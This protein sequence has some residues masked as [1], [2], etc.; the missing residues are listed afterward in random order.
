[1]CGFQH[2]D[3]HI[4]NGGRSNNDMYYDEMEGMRHVFG[5][6]KNYAFFMEQQRAAAEKEERDFRKA[7]EKSLR[8]EKAE[9][10]RTT[11]RKDQDQ[12]YKVGC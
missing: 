10:E 4:Y 1:M 12:E 8:D 2:P 9:I 11:V 6:D 5:N 7:M 3:N